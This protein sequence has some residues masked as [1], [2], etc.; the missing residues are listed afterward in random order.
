V[1]VKAGD[2]P[3]TSWIQAGSKIGVIVGADWELH[4]RP[5]IDVAHLMFLLAYAA[6]QSGWKDVKANFEREDELFAAVASGFSW[7]ATWA[8]E[9][10]LMRG[11]HRYEE[12]RADI[13]GRILFGQHL[14]RSGGVPLPVHVAFDE[15]TV[16]V[17]ENKMLRT[18]TQ[19]LLRLPRVTGNTRLRL[20]RLRA[21]LEEVDPLTDWRGIKAPKIS[22]L[23]QRYAA[24][25]RLAELILAS[26]SIS[27]N[28]GDVGS[29]T[30]VFDMNKVFEDFVTAAFR[31][32]MRTFGGEVRSQS[33]THSLDE[34]AILT[35]KPDLAWW[36]GGACHAVLDAKYKPILDG[37]MRNGDAYQMLAY[38]TA[39]R[40]PRGYLV[41]ARDSGVEPRVH[42]V[43]NAGQQIVVATLDV[44]EEPDHLLAQVDQLASAVASDLSPALTHAA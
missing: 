22:R 8:I 37:V 34:A 32:S 28:P 2:S 23:N 7:H 12:R 1:E 4:V 44:T 3:G 18:A 43:R 41:Y 16:D 36:V 31:N 17:L 9:R 30:F 10:G 20:L 5:H 35:L 27:S 42:T 19:L 14:A 33:Q 38:M 13:R 39:Y 40:L 6:D 29:T 11:Y 24:A 15:F 21:I 26:A 25:L